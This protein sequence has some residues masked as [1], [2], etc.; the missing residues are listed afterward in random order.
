MPLTEILVPGG[1][2]AY[3][4]TVT[5]SLWI[6]RSPGAA[7]GIG[8]PPICEPSNNGGSI[9]MLSESGRDGT[10]ESVPLTFFFASTGIR[11]SVGYIVGGG[12]KQNAQHRMRAFCW[13][14]YT[15]SDLKGLAS[16]QNV[17]LSLL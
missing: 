3:P 2:L 13:T 16:S 12:Q 15:T 6:T 1:K 11:V 9:N 17:R 10:S 8:A 4:P 7:N 14:A 5:E